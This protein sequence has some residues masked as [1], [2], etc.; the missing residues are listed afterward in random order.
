MI[1]EPLALTACSIGLTDLWLL[2][3]LP[4]VAEFALE[5]ME[6]DVFAALA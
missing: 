1:D 3:L 5:R 4:S 2:P 6:P